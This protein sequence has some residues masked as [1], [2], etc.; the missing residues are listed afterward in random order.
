[1][2][3][4]EVFWTDTAVHS[5]NSIYHFVSS[6]WEESVAAEFESIVDNAV[7]HLSEFP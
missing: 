4:K 5:Q 3:K 7:E 1:M 6:K 2:S